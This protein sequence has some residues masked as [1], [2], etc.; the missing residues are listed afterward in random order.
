MSN[1]TSRP[2]DGDL[3]ARASV[4]NALSGSLDRGKNGLASVPG[5]LQ[6]VLTED[7]WR[8][9]V[10]ARDEEVRHDDFRDFV[11]TPPLR[12]LGA[13]EEL[14]R[15]L[16]GDDIDVL[17]LLDQALVRKPG[18]PAG[19]TLTA[20]ANRTAAVSATV[21]VEEAPDRE[22]VQETVSNRHS[23]VEPRPAG[24]TRARAV[25]KLQEHRPDLLDKV[26]SGEIKSVNAAMVQAGFR[27]KTATVPLT[28]PEKIA[29]ILRAELDEE[30]LARLIELLLTK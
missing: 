4:I 23:L 20:A 22:Q 5:L 11:T 21:D 3:R 1:G 28:R 29:K 25:R 16:V 24:T 9:F 10:T 12:G 6:Q 2:G 26:K 18:R 14:I 17:R 7:K 19:T 15:R 8:H 30:D 13:T 27:E